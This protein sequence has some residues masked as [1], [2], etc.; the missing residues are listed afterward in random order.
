MNTKSRIGALL[1]SAAVLAGAVG[2]TAGPA[3]ASAAP[4]QSGATLF[5]IQDPVHPNN[6]RLAIMGTYPMQQ[7][8]AVGFLNNINNGKCEGSMFYYLYGD[9]GDPQHIHTL[10]F[11]GAH[12]DGEGYLK[13]TSEGLGYRREFALRKN[14]LNEDSDGQDEIYAQAN[15][16]DSDCNTRIQ[17]TQVIRDSF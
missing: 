8:D 14:F 1:S 9:D 16:L 7:A 12:E 2:L 4:A 3:P 5:V 13:A 10:H 6:Y 17:T 11:P 15:F